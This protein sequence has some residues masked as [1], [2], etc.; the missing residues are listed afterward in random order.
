MKKNFAILGL[1]LFAFFINVNHA[2]KESNIVVDDLET[3]CEHL[4][5]LI[6][7]INEQVELVNSVPLKDITGIKKAKLDSLKNIHEEIGSS[8]QEKG[9]EKSEIE[10]CESY[11]EF[12]ELMQSAI[13]KLSECYQSLED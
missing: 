11:D 7:I 9:I 10:E 5:A 1:M 3:A 8:I 6:I 4:D 2:Q 12:T 13:P